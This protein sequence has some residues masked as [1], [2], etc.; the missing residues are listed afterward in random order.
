[1]AQAT[2]TSIKPEPFVNDAG[3]KTLGM[4][5]PATLLALAYEVIKE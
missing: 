4:A 5:V 2:R 3:A 1:M